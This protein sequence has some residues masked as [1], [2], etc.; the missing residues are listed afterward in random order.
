[1]VRLSVSE[2]LLITSEMSVTEIA[3][4]TGFSDLS[5]FTHR[6]T[7]KNGI[8]PRDY[9]KRYRLRRRRSSRPRRSC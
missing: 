6:F 5:Y 2:R 7:I 1:A 4:S 3:Y 8:A 9:R